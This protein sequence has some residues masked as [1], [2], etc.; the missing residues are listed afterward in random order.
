MKSIF[1]ADAH[2]LEPEASVY[3]ELLEF[4]HQLP[5]DLENLFILGDFFDFWYGYQNLVHTVY[6]PVISTLRKLSE[7]GLNIYFLA[8][9]HE[10]NFGP[11]LENLACSCHLDELVMKLDGQ[12]IYMTHGDQLNRDDF[13]NHCWRTFIR[14]PLVLR[15]IA[16][17]PPDL[18]WKTACWL[19]KKSRANGNADKKI[20]PQVF[21]SV[22]A[23]LRGPVDAAV[24]GHF[25]QPRF[26]TFMTPTGPRSLYLLG[27][28]AD[29][30]AYL[31]H[32]EGRFMFRT[33]TPS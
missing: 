28:W 1:I 21:T 13:G 22:A 10:I 30:R 18:V 4:L 8:G 24:I 7:Q 29:D 9:N 32:D 33:Y 16:I 14:H 23:I 6:L 11:G 5:D 25:H 15:F 12:R 20:P 3:R 17:L 2:L 19:S 26:E 27:S 31:I